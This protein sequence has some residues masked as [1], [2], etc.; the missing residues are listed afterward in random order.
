M[1]LTSIAAI[2]STTSREVERSSETTETL[3][4]IINVFLGESGFLW[5]GVVFLVAAIFLGHFISRQVPKPL[6]VRIAWVVSHIPNV[7]PY[8]NILVVL[9]GFSGISL[10]GG[11]VWTRLFDV[12]LDVSSYAMTCAGMTLGVVTLIL[13][14]WTLHQTRRLEILKGDTIQHFGILVKRL[15]EDISLLEETYKASVDKDLD[16]FRLIIVTNNPYFG[17]LSFA[18]SERDKEI[19]KDFKNAIGSYAEHLEK[20]DNKVKVICTTDEEMKKFEKPYFSDS[21]EDE[22]ETA[23]IETTRFLTTLKESL[24]DNAIVR[25]PLRIS[26][27]QYAVIGD[28]VYEFLLKPAGNK[29]RIT[30]IDKVVRI[31]DRDVADRFQ[32]FSEFLVELIELHVSVRGSTPLTFPRWGDHLL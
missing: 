15:T 31:E 3:Q 24:G 26:D 5:I 29:S 25:C 17:V 21:E 28:V 2:A 11:F 7:P 22:R 30:D 20:D 6:H 8:M 16:R 14:T 23:R 9:L 27:A 4:V 13:T 10:I 12:N 19:A 32:R 18:R 1:G